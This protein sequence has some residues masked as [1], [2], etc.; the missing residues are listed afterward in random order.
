MSNEIKVF[1]FTKSETV[2]ELNVIRN[3]SERLGYESFNPNIVKYN[4]DIHVHIYKSI[5]HEC[6][7]LHKSS[8]VIRRV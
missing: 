7:I 5:R 4:F 6:H 2:E 1:S 3:Q 8:L